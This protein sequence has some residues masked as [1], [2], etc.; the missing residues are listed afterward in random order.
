MDRIREIRAGQSAGSSTF[1]AGTPDFFG[2]IVVGRN[3]LADQCRN[4]R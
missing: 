4:I 2:S 3:S 1:G